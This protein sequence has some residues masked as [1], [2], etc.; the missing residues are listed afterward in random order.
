MIRP[1]TIIWFCIV[2]A[3]GYAMFQVKY[4][5]MQQE[6]TLAG[7][8]KHITDDREQ[9]RVLDAEWTYLTRPARLQQLADR[10]L[11]LQGVSSAQIVDLNTVPTRDAATAPLVAT[12][13]QLAPATAVAATAR[14]APVQ[15]APTQNAKVVEHATPESSDELAARIMSPRIASALQK[16]VP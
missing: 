8:N 9:I 1:G 4:E 7:I 2:V 10:F 16:P 11:H 3:V 13:P 5:V 12:T 6:Q 15:N 14:V